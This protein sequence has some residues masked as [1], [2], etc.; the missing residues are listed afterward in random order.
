MRLFG[1]EFSV[2]RAG[3]KA[4]APAVAVGMPTSSHFGG[5]LG[6]GSGIKD[7]TAY[8][9]ID[10]IVRSMPFVD[11]GLRKYCRLCGGFSVRSKDPRTQDTLNSWL[12][13]ATENG[14]PMPQEVVLVDWVQR[15]FESWLAR[16]LR[17]MLTYGKACGEVVLDGAGRD[18]YQLVNLAS[19]SVALQYDEGTLVYGQK[20]NLGHINWFENQDLFLYNINGPEG[21]DPH[22]VSLLRSAPWLSNIFLTIENAT[23][24]LWQRNG[25]PPQLLDLQLPD[26]NPGEVINNAVATNIE[27]LIRSAWK[28]A[29][30]DRFQ[31]DGIRDFTMVHHG[32]F[33]AKTIGADLKELNLETAFRAMAEQIVSGIELPPFMLGI[34]WSTTERLSQQQ[35]DAIISCVEAVRREVEPDCLHVCELKRD[36]LGLRGDLE[37]VWQDVS[38]QDRVEQAKADQMEA[39]AEKIMH[40]LAVDRWRQGFITQEDAARMDMG[41][42]WEGDIATVL[43]APV[44]AT[45]APAFGGAMSAGGNGKALAARFA[46]Y[47]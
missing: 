14:S 31:A 35:A 1:L 25:A 24:Q 23:R 19:R 10:K 21:D 26:P 6:Y 2:R 3:G 5:V 46:N 36:L 39:Q 30:L 12:G 4:Q 20:D 41:E 40:D 15:G 8:D 11:T 44:S 33:A 13:H 47:P 43:A 18:V 9:D 22:G 45:P 16:H 27:G 32:T 7:S 34:Q 37:A 28:A 42:E 29:Q 38:L 17:S